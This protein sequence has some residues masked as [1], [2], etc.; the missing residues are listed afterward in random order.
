MQ[1]MAHPNPD[2]SLDVTLRGRAV[3]GGRRPR[4]GSGVTRARILDRLGG[5]DREWSIPELAA[6]LGLHPNSIRTQLDLLVDAGRIV[7]SPAVTGRRGRPPLRYR[8]VRQIDAGAP[9][10]DL[11]AVLAFQLGEAPDAAERALAAGERWGRSAVA[12]EPPADPG[13]SSGESM[14]QLLAILETSG[15]RPETA[16]HGGPIRLRRCPFL[17]LARDQ[18]EVVCAVHLGLIRGVLEATGSA[19][20]ADRLEPLVEPDLCLAH[21]RRRDPGAIA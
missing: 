19:L 15:F 9:Y 4:F 7:R 1:A 17:P 5:G 3:G 16:A 6:D 10:R 8:A 14:D 2:V 18:S 11:A 20:D 13:R 21:L 12:A